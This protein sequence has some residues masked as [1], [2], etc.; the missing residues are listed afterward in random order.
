M[1]ILTAEPTP[2]TP[3]PAR[4]L[5]LYQKDKS[6]KLNYKTGEDHHLSLQLQRGTTSDHARLDYQIRWWTPQGWGASLRSNSDLQRLATNRPSQRYLF[7][8]LRKERSQKTQ[9]QRLVLLHRWPGRQK[10]A[11]EQNWHTDLPREGWL[12]RNTGIIH[13]RGCSNKEPPKCGH[14]IFTQLFYLL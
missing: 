8:N 6:E 3:V 4:P 7:F 11:G 9:G 1:Q 2:R 5:L 14:C 10:W 12:L 13:K